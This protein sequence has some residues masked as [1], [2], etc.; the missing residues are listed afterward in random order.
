MTGYALNECAAI[1]E[2]LIARGIPE[3]EI[4][5]IHEA[6]TE[7]KKKELFEKVR[8]GDVRVLFGILLYRRMRLRSRALCT[9][10]HRW[11]RMFMGTSRE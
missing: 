5:F 4:A 2:K 6:R 1:R 11:E 9:I 10:R 8:H 3:K 7:V